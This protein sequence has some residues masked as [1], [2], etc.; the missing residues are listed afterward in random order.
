MH[1]ADLEAGAVAGKTARPKGGEAALVR[2]LGERIGL[3][4]ELRELAAAEEIADDGGERLRIDQLLRRHALDVHVEQRHALLDQ[5]LRAGQADAALVGEQFAHGADAA[6]AEVIDVVQCCL[7][8][9]W[10]RRMRYLVAATKSSLVMMR[11]S[12]STLMP[13]FWLIL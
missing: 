1:V 13:S 8:P 12:R 7:R 11:E 5:A 2:Q 6:A 9:F 10:R 4:H 3:V